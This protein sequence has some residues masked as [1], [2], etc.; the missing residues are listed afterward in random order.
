V[1]TGLFSSLGLCRAA[2]V[3]RRFASL[4]AA[5]SLLPTGSQARAQAP[6]DTCGQNQAAYTIPGTGGTVSGDFSGSSLDFS[7]SG[8]GIVDRDI[9]YYFTP[10]VSASYRFSTC[11][12]TMNIDTTVSIHTGC[13]ARSSNLVSG[14][15]ACN[16]NA[17]GNRSQFDSGL[18]IAGTPVVIRVGYD[19]HIFVGD[20]FTLTVSLAPLGACCDR[21]TGTCTFVV[22]GGCTFTNGY[23]GDGTLCS[24][25]PCPDPG[26]CCF[27]LPRGCEMVVSGA[28]GS[29]GIYLGDGTVCFP[30]SCPELAACCSPTTGNCSVQA[31]P[32]PSGETF[33]GADAT[34]TPSPCLTNRTCGTAQTITA[35]YSA[36]F[37]TIGGTLGP[38]P[39]CD[40]WAVNARTVWFRVVGNGMTMHASACDTNPD[41]GRIPI[42][43]VYCA[44]SG[45]CGIG[46]AGLLCVGSSGASGCA[47]HSWFASAGTAYYLAVFGFQAQT[48]PINFA[49]SQTPGGTASPCASDR[50]PIDIAGVANGDPE[51]CGQNFMSSCATARPFALAVDFW[52]TTFA[53]S[54][55]RDF[56]YWEMGILPGTVGD[57]TSWVDI[58]YAVE[59]PALVQLRSFQ[60]SGAMF[61]SPKLLNYRDGGPACPRDPAVVQA[62]VE[63]G[64][65]LGLLITSNEFGGIPCVPG[66]NVY[67]L[68]I[69]LSTLGACCISSVCGLNVESDC[70]SQSGTFFGL[71]TTCNGPGACTQPT[72]GACCVGSSCGVAAAASCTGPNTRYAGNGSACNTPG[73]GTTPCCKADFNQSG[74]TTV[75][76]IFDFLAAYFAGDP[77]ADIGGGGLSVQDIF[78]FLAAYFTGC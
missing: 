56:D 67:R 27:P 71:N 54:N 24:P 32:C 43:N 46:N 14:G 76:D 6:N 16:D 64:V 8:C 72:T 12:S 11:S 23:L 70:A 35:P 38:T 40:K 59:F 52:G 60:C 36:S 47:S 15:T 44:A 42:V 37:S 21:S 45:S 75:Q 63:S 51:L 78:D 58:T 34:C 68:K 33:Y 48:L 49:L 50:C 30:N 29:S 13:P 3:F 62:R 41:F 74:Q 1:I 77:A 2:P 39:F 25:D 53:Q 10:A 17:C 5:A 55:T 22:T 73:N 26:A 57:G 19:Q 61:Y 65:L 31:A 18:L 69:T 28:C 4:I 66:G 20:D 7:G 9:Y